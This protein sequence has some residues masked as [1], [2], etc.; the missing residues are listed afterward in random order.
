MTTA[1]L[2]RIARDVVPPVG[3]TGWR[4]TVVGPREHAVVPIIDGRLDG[5]PVWRGAQR[6]IYRL[7][8]I[9]EGRPA[10]RRAREIPAAPIERSGEGNREPDRAL[11][12]A[13]VAGASSGKEP[14]RL[15]AG[16]DEPLPAD[17]RSNRRTHDGACR[18]RAARRHAGPKA[19]RAD[20]DGAV[21]VSD[22][23]R[24]SDPASRPGHDFVGDGAAGVAS[25][26]ETRPDLAVGSG[27]AAATGAGGALPPGAPTPAPHRAIN[28]PSFAGPPAVPTRGDGIQLALRLPSG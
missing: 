12:E 22:P 27:T 7:M 11:P 9:L 2:E 25:P 1:E 16:C 19:G 8:D 24:P 18:V 21:T 6:D 15:C 26:A 3:A 17:A 14:V 5:K 10:S 28:Q 4:A 13:S 20:T 23:Q